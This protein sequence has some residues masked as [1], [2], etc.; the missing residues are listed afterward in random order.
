MKNILGNFKFLS[1]ETENQIKL[2]YGLLSDFNLE[3]L[4]KIGAKDDYIDNLKTTIENDCFS[5]I[6]TLKTDTS[7]DVI[8]RIRAVHIICIN[9]ERIA[10]FCV[11]ITRQTRYLSSNAFIQQYDYKTMFK[12]IQQSI[13]SITTVYEDCDLTGA[14]HICKAEFELDRLWEENFKILLEDLKKGEGVTDLITTIFIFRYL[15]RIGDSILNI[16]EA[17]IFG[18]IGDRIKIRQFEALERTLT[19]SGFDG[20]LNDIDFASI[21]G[22]RSGCR[23]SKVSRKKPS[24][25]K[26]QEIFTEGEIKKI[27]KKH[28]NI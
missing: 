16:G 20:T 18:I 15:E 5:R 22:S 11:N 12:V 8:N 2:T 19:E 21:W 17:L 3:V 27:K 24:G 25:F 6:A 9:L 26:A 28:E 23:I 4:E 14:L 7:Q 10:D 13:T 1:I